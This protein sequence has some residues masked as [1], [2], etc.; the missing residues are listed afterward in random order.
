MKIF[1]RALALLAL[2]A[3]LLTGCTTGGGSS[4]SSTAAS[5][6]PATSVAASE[7]ASETESQAGS[8]ASALPEKNDY[9]E[10]TYK[11]TESLEK[12][13]INGRY[14]VTNAGDAGGYVPCISFDNTA[15]LLAFN[16][17]CE[18][19][20]TITMTVETLT[21]D[22]DV[23]KHFL[24]VVDGAEK[25]MS[26]T[27]QKGMTVK[28]KLTVA[29]GLKRGNHT[30]E[31]YRQFESGQGMCDLIS[32]TVNGVLTERPKNKAM[33]IEFFGDSITAGY[34]NLTTGSDSE[35]T[36]FSSKSSGTDTYAFLTAKALNADMYAVAQSGVAY[37]WGVGQR[38]IYHFWNKIA[39][40]RAELG[41]YKA[42]RQPD[43]V[44]INLGT[45]DGGYKSKGYTEK[46]LTE[47][48]VKLMQTVRKDRPNAKI[49]WFYGM[50][51]NGINTEIKNAVDE[52][53]GAAKGFYYCEGQKGQ[54]GG[55]GHPN[56]EEHKANAD[57][58]A[59]FIKGI[60]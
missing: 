14:A 41:D 53:G 16:A 22:V 55:G 38:D 57:I 5:K 47:A 56:K 30:F 25:R 49:V 21:S 48:A 51:G 50:M 7:T 44:V 6:K 42:D 4:A 10:N 23:N 37:T 58:L 59:N 20:V 8:I 27:G 24:V 32:I 29:E 19:A 15:A 43:V 54:S 39:F 31:V 11:I 52:M 12:L 1:T 60:M 18:G 34:G 17:D 26:V 2:S 40:R 28:A 9:S 33:F 13:K 3:L 35:N 36:S 46:Q 45:N